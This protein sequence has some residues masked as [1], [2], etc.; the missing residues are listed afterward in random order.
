[1]NSV[2]AIRAKEEGLC[3]FGQV[4]I[5][6]YLCSSYVCQRETA[7]TGLVLSSPCCSNSAVA[8][9][10]VRLVKRAGALCYARP[11][12]G[13]CDMRRSFSILP[14]LLLFASCTTSAAPD[15]TVTYGIVFDG[16]GAPSVVGSHLLTWDGATSSFTAPESLVLLYRGTQY[17][18]PLADP[19]QQKATDPTHDKY[20][21]GTGVGPDGHAELYVIDLDTSRMIYTFHG[22]VGE[23][24]PGGAGPVGLIQGRQTHHESPT[25]ASW[26]SEQ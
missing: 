10:V 1:M 24:I 2:Q 21:W 26:T 25:I 14:A 13:G 7:V 17:T 15:V 6:Y 22:S 19:K 4:L 8:A 9:S 12:A 16:D 5:S 20:E 11:P 18:L 3:R 23:T